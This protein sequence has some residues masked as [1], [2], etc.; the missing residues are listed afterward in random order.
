MRAISPKVFGPED[1][2]LSPNK[3]QTGIAGLNE[4]APVAVQAEF[5]CGDDAG[6][7]SQFYGFDLVRGNNEA[8]AD[9]SDEAVCAHVLLGWAT[10]WPLLHCVLGERSEDQ[11]RCISKDRTLTGSG[12]A[13]GAPE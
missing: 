4:L 9:V 11:E 2:D 12:F 8:E 13:C 6:V 1:A 3:E 5:A 7:C 10:T